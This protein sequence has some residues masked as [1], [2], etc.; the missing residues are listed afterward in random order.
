[1]AA[2]LQKASVPPS[3]MPLISPS[4]LLQAYLSQKLPTRPSNRNPTQTR[5]IHLNLGS[6][7][8]C[9]GSSLVKVGESTVVCGIR[10]EILPVREIAHYS[11]GV[12]TQDVEELDEEI[13]DEQYEAVTLNNL[14]VPNL[15]L[16][17]NCNPSFP[18][19]VAPSTLAQ[20]ISQRILSLLHTSRLVRVSDLEIRHT[21][22]A[23]ISTDLDPD[24]PAYIEP[25]E[26]VLKAYWT[27]YIDCVC[28]SY[29]GEENTFDTTVLATVAALKNIRIPQA[30]WDEDLKQV[31]CDADLSRSKPLQLRSIPCPLS[32]AVFAMDARLYQGKVTHLNSNSVLQT[33]KDL[34][35]LLLDTDAF[36]DGICEEKG[37]IIIDCST[38]HT[39][40]LRVEKAGGGGC[41]DLTGMQEILQHCETRWKI[42]NHLLENA[43]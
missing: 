27:L 3:S 41:L 11:G 25:E 2:T 30:R 33:K 34:S 29:G 10:A 36:E 5:P 42:W 4:A 12:V 24:D 39:K 20:S 22:D 15:E 1:M 18:P 43:G 26:D 37:S 38:G 9:N 6:L 19:N 13:E 21:S 7:T 17:T 14:L 16:G 35:V 23:A 28:L 32:F 40:I 8:H 31:F